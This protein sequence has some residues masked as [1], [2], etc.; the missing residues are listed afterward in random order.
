VIDRLSDESIDK[1]LND[2]EN[3][4]RKD[5]KMT[6]PEKYTLMTQ[7]GDAIIKRRIAV[8]IEDLQLEVE[9]VKVCLETLVEK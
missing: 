8:A 2:L 4:I 6:W 7:L 5:T 1:M 3:E 9:G